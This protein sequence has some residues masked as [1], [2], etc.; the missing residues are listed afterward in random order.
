[1]FEEALK[2][3]KLFK[4]QTCLEEITELYYSVLNSPKGDIVEIGSATGGTTIMLIKAAEQVNKTVYSIDPYPEE[5]EGKI[6][7]FKP[8]LVKGYRESFKKNILNGNY[9]NIIQLNSNISECI[10]KIPNEL[11]VAFIDG[12]HEFSNV[13]TEFDL[14]YPRVVSDGWIFI[15]DTGSLQGQLTRTEK[16]GLYRVWEEFNKPE[17][18]KTI[19]GV[20]A[21]ISPMFCGQKK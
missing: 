17:L 20:G 10:D 1:M 3:W 4:S 21:E 14:I 16:N 5:L 13:K 15:H 11:S 2:L 7:K 19:K 18:F 9:K 6:I 8:G 12:L